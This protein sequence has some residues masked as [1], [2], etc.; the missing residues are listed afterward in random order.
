MNV[1]L[2]IAPEMIAAGVEAMKEASTARMTDGE[3]CIEIYLAMY[4]IAIKTLRERPE[5][6][7]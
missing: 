1:P 6:V 5:T 3:I 7:H 4:G 2:Y